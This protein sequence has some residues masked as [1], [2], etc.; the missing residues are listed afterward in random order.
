V[1]GDGEVPRR[2]NTGGGNQIQL[3]KDLEAKDGYS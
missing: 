2:Q 3:N 1:Q